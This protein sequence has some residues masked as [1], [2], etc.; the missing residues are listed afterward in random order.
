MK[1]RNVPA[2]RQDIAR[3]V[4]SKSK[5]APQGTRGCGSPF[6]QQVFGVPE[7]Q[8]EAECNDNLLVMVQIESAD[9]IRNIEEIASVPGLDVLFV[10]PFDLAKSMDI[11]FGGDEHEAAIDKVLQTAK[12]N[13][14]KSAIFC[15]SSNGI[16][17]PGEV[18]DSQA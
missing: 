8:Y 15:M 1:R 10:G 16:L 12:K 7:A 5:Y 2:D 9:G 14:K 18:A 17:L 13:G 4:V 6:T 11:K 3:N